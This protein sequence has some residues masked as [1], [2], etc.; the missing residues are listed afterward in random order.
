[1]LDAMMMGKRAGGNLTKLVIAAKRG[2]LRGQPN[3]LAG[4]DLVCGE[5]LYGHHDL[6]I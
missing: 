2:S 3:D 6:L 1:M 4:L 5:G